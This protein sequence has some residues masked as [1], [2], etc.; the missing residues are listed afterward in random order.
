[1]DEFEVSYTLDNEQQFWDELEEIISTPCITHSQIDS[2]LRLYLRFTTNYREEYLLSEY[3]IARCACMFLDSALF[4][5][6]DA[7][8]RNQLEDAANT[9][10][11]LS[12]IL[13]FDGRQN[14][15]TT[16]EAMNG[17]GAFPRLVELIGRQAD[18]DDG[19]LHRRL[20]ELLYEMSRIQKIDVGDL[21]IIDDAFVAYLFQIIEELSNDVN[22]PYHYPVIRVLLVLNE[23]YMVCAH[24]PGGQGQGQ[25]DSSTTTAAAT[26]TTTTTPLT[27]RVI[28][29]LS[30]HGWAYK[31]F[32]ENLILLLNRENETSLQLL[33]LKLLYLLFT[34]PA[35]YEYFYTNDLRVLVD[36]MIR[37]LL[38]IPDD[39]EALRHTYLRVLYPLLCHTQLRHPPHYKRD[40]ILRLLNMLSVENSAHFNPLDET[41]R[42]LT[43]R[44]L[45][46]PW[47]LVLQQ[48]KEGTE[49]KEKEKEKE[50]GRGR[51]LLGIS[52]SGPA[53]DSALSVLEVAGLK[54]RPGVLTG[55]RRGGGGGGG[56]G[57]GCEGQRD[58]CDDGG[59]AGGN[60]VMLLGEGEKVG[61]GEGPSV[62]VIGEA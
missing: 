48:Q 10:H 57:A 53:G 36:V 55:S 26:T 30:M 25:T 12:S 23:Q 21:R 52:L 24:E 15:G 14:N 3:D 37:N 61:G 58:G 11:L 51:G 13:Y 20:L 43:R 49:G 62:V 54:E 1:M 46:V 16:F 44:C 39:A 17:E 38:D 32:G 42:R 22:D 40:E 59:A 4:K 50:A 56:G 7:Y 29:V 41:T 6:H 35:T 19:L 9:L 31:T 28:K 34:T 18:D 60:G 27:N 8:I 33:I 45:K 2:V 5:A 47:L